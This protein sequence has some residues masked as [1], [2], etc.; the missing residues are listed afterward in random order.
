MYNFINDKYKIDFAVPKG[1]QE[2]ID[3]AEK[4]DKENDYGNYAIYADDID[5]IAK[6]CCGAGLL[7]REQWDILCLRYEQ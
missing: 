5:V 6:N 1:L 7:T 4:A 3:Y 2:Y